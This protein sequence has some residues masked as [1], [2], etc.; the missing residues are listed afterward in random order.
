MSPG[1]FWGGGLIA[2]AGTAQTLIELAC[3]IICDMCHMGKFTG[4][5]AAVET[6]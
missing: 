6:W 3:Q 4:T 1:P 2:H 5:S